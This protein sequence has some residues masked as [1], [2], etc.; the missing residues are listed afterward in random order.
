MSWEQAIPVAAQV[1]GQALGAAFGGKGRKS[2]TNITGRQIDTPDYD[3]K[4]FLTDSGN[5]RTMLQPGDLWNQRRNLLTENLAGLTDLQGQVNPAFGRLTQ[6]ARESVENA[7]SRAVGNLRDTLARR[8]LTGSSFG[9]NAVIQAE[10]EFAQADNEAQAK[11]IIQEIA[12]S[13][14]LIDRKSA[15]M[16]QEVNN[17]LNE[18]NIAAG[19]GANFAQSIQSQNQIDKMFAAQEAQA[20]GSFWGNLA[21]QLGNAIAEGVSPGSTPGGLNRQ[22]LQRLIDNIGR[23]PPYKA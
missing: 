3:L 15:L 20:A 12:L 7:R 18:L 6:A 19:V 5:I 4:S 17:S 22:L 10:R 9:D 2:G 8:R 13:S 11:S 21:G 23:T 14:E 16:Q 1:G